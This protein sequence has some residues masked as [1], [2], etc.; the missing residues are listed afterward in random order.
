VGDGYVVAVDEREALE[1]FQQFI[2]SIP[3]VFAGAGAQAEPEITVAEVFH[4][5]DEF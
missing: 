1:Q 4:T 3:D 2:A 5:A